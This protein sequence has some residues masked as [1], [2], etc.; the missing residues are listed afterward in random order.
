[1]TYEEFCNEWIPLGESL[2]HTAMGMLGS[3][4][5]AE[6]ALQDLFIK[7]WRQRDTLDH[8]YN[9]GAYASRMIRNICIDRHRAQRPADRLPDGFEPCDDSVSDAADTERVRL[10]ADAIRRLPGNQRK[11]LEMR[12]L[13]GLT[14]DEISART[15][16]SP[17]T[18]RVLVSRARKTLKR[19]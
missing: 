6:D 9:P 16:M 3:R 10:V 19:I 4:E 5:D 11:A 8:V 1:M 13:M 18:L 2:L 15:G 7:L 14:Y 17:L 12:T